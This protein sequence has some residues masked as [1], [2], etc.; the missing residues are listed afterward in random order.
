MGFGTV[1]PTTDAGYVV[2]YFSMLVGVIVNVFVFSAVLAKF[3]A[4][5]KDLVWSTKAV[6]SRRDGV[7]TLL[8]RVGRVGT[9]HHV[10]LQS[11]HGSI[12]E[13]QDGPCS[14]QSDTPECRQ[15]YAW[16]TC[17][18]TRCTTPRSASRS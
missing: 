2:G 3:Q 4:P 8:V 12:D 7:P 18:A 14:N 13:S 6:M 1:M 11:T 16:V 5:Q 10:C 9:F 17:G 15:P